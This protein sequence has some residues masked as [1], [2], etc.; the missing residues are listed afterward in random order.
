M[1]WVAYLGR[2]L[3][4]RETPRGIVDLELAG[5][6]GRVIDILEIWDVDGIEAAIVQTWVDCLF[7]LL[8]PVTLSLACWLL[9]ASVWPRIGRLIAGLAL[10]AAPLDA[11]EN[12]LMVGMLDREFASWAPEWT[13]FLATV[14]FGLVIAAGLYLALGGGVWLWRTD[15]PPRDG[16]G[17]SA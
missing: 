7:L 2:S 17:R 8:Y 15:Q 10:F 9:S 6:V 14:K 11:A 3:E 16:Q 13:A 1:A 5:S 12:W 4:S